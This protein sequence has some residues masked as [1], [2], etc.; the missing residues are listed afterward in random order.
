MINFFKGMNYFFQG[1]KKLS[2]P[3]LKRF[4][5]IPIVFNFLLFTSLFYLSYHYLLPYAHYYIDKLPSWL[6]FLSSLIIVFLVITFL[7]L[8]LAMFTVM[9]N[10]IAAPFNGL[11]AEKVQKII[12]GRAVPSVAF[13]TMAVRSLKRQGKFLR[14]FIPRFLGM[15]VLFFVPFIQPIFP[16]IW[17]IFTA[18][19]LSMQFQ[20][21][22]MDNNLVGFEQ[23]KQEI[24]INTM[25]SL[26][27]GASINLASFIP[28]FNVLTLP[29]AVI[30]STMLYC[31]THQE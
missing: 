25:R 15:G 22:P 18:W 16:V 10:I 24:K 27:F 23:M 29:A 8:F 17:F 21:V 26:G 5:I 11:L 2:T 31:D 3:G 4:I 20:D 30:G 14:Y 1:L 12:Y 7:L 9:F 19:M 6:S 28:F 13:S